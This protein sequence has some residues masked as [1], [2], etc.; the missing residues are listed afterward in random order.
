MNNIKND[1]NLREAISRREQK[2]PPMPADLNERVM[3]RLSSLPLTPSEG[4]GTLSRFSSLSLWRGRGLRLVGAIAATVLLLL[5][6]HFT[7]KPVEEQPLVAQVPV[8]APQPEKPVVTENVIEPQQS[9]K[10]EK[11][12]KLAESAK[13]VK[14]EKPAEAKENLGS[15]SPRRGQGVRL[16]EDLSLVIPADKQALVDI[17][18]AE[19]ALQVAYELQ[20]QQ[21]ELRAYAASLMGVE[22]PQPQSIIA[23]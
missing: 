16:E 14:A 13:P 17:Y 15:L 20:A 6:F 5:A 1:I 9:T 21:E 4:R 19:E 18:L 12:Q 11:P 7:Q 10:A 2:L 3:K 23:F 22:E 8:A